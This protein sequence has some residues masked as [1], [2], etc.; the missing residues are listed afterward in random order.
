MSKGFKI[1]VLILSLIILVG[2]TIA[3]RMWNKPNRDVAKEKGIEITAAQ[4]VTEFQQNEAAANA[5]YLNKPIQVSGTVS[6]VAANQEGITTVLLSSNDAMTGVFCT[7]KENNPNIKT[8]TPVVIKGICN[9]MLS[10]VRLGEA[11]MVK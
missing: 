6:N 5:K 7:L 4:L 11:I 1:T 8:G 2:G 3:Y 9:G 10:D